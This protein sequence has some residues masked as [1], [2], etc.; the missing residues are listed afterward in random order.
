[1]NNIILY[2]T[3]VLIWGTTWF[4]IKLQVGYA[5]NEISIL[6]RATLAALCLYVWCKFKGISLKH[7]MKDHLFFCLLGLAMFSLHLLFVYKATT[8]IVSGV[9][10]V[11]FSC[12]S[13]LSIL[14]NYIFFR[15]KPQLNVLIGVLF[16]ISGICLFFWHEVTHVSLQ[17]ST[18]TGLGLASAGTVIFSFGSMISKRNQNHGLEIVPSMTIGMMYG[19]LAMLVYTLMHGTPLVLPQSLTYWVSLLYLVIPGSIIA[20]LCYLKLNKNIGPELAGYTTVIF[21]VVALFVSWLLEGY[22]W[23]IADFF[24]FL[25]VALG[26]IL[27]MSKKRIVKIQLL[28]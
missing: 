12:L 9:V 5:P 8:Y 14:N 27:V 18:L 4:A 20:F 13:F 28:S 15:I 19:T 10:A 2:L 22:H 11:V 21:P 1:M 7:K 25:L 17:E 3:T 26:N 6:Y 16:G 23:S 24:G